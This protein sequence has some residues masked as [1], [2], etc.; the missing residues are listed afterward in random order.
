MY[1]KKFLSVQNST[2][3]SLKKGPNRGSGKLARNSYHMPW[4]WRDPSPTW[5]CAMRM[6]YRFTPLSKDERE[7]LET[8]LLEEMDV[9][10]WF[11]V[12]YSSIFAEEIFV[13]TQ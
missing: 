13:T 12:T 2:H 6:H 11:V 3:P 1:G 10:S 8:I 9:Q 4:Q 5:R 7:L